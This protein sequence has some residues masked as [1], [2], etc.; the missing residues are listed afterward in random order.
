MEADTSLIRYFISFVDASDAHTAREDILTKHRGHIQSKLLGSTAVRLGFAKQESA[1]QTPGTALHSRLSSVT[2]G[3]AVA[4]PVAGTSSLLASNNSPGGMDGH[5]QT[6]PTRALWIGTIP[7]STT[8]TDL[9]NVFAPFG[10]IESA[11]VLA[12]KQCGFCNFENLDD[13]VRARTAL[14]GLEF[15]GPEVGPIKIGYARV[16]NK[17]PE[18]PTVLDDSQIPAAAAYQSLKRLGGATA[19]PLDEQISSGHLEN[20]RSPMALQLA[21]NGLN[22]VGPHSA[23]ALTQSLKPAAGLSP[24]AV[25]R[26][27]DAT[28]PQ[29]GVPMPGISEQ[30]AL[31]R[32][33]S[34]DVG[35]AE[36]HAQAV[37]GR[38]LP[39]FTRYMVLE[40]D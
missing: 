16:P 33:L 36:I 10:P 38:L 7:P 2:P 35:D 24:S 9:L 28:T 32:E 25:A 23:A 13:A 22:A 6:S 29:L 39:P 27:L 11:R 19:V 8:S 3:I 31:M 34:G 4:A 37:A 20:F 12:N 26:E 40:L 18:A 21:A 30:Q 15:L 17:M 14:N 1:P 5:L